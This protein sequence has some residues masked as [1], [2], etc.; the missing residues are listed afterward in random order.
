MSAW[1]FKGHKDSTVERYVMSFQLSNHIYA[2]QCKGDMT[3][4][5]YKYTWKKNK[6]MFYERINL[7][8][9]TGQVTLISKIMADVN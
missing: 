1:I 4:Q 5:S 3:K 7:L 6:V 8:K 2:Q 9:N